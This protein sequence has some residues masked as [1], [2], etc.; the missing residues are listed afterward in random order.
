MRMDTRTQRVGPCYLKGRGVNYKFGN[1][2]NWRRWAWNRVDE[3][4]AVPAREANVLYLA[5]AEDLDRP[6]A[7]AH[8]FRDHNLIAVDLSKHTVASLRERRTISIKDRIEDVLQA[9]PRT[10]EIHF[11]NLDLCCGFELRL[12]NSI[13]R[14]LLNPAFVR[15]V[16]LI[17]FQRGRESNGMEIVRQHD[18]DAILATGDAKHRAA[19]F[20]AAFYG[21]SDTIRSSFYSY[22]SEAGVVMDSA[23]FSRH[24]GLVGSGIADY[25]RRNFGKRDHLRRERPK[26]TRKIAAALAHQTMRKQEL[27]S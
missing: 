27:V 11:V 6:I 23:V 9:W 24:I 13:V 1:K 7:K 17:N 15:S 5:G 2:N 20:L 19:I 3:Q 12:C 25:L 16:V 21:G 10:R 18:R 22:R 14:G 8:G 26:T 4:L